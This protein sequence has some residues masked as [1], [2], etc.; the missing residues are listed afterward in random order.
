MIK[1]A[2]PTK[3]NPPKAK[4][5]LLTQLKDPMT[6]E[7]ALNT[8]QNNIADTE[9][10]LVGIGG[11]KVIHCPVLDISSCLFDRS[12]NPCTTGFD[13]GLCKRSTKCVIRLKYTPI[14]F[15]K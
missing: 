8:Y 7:P 1:V 10:E 13:F 6:I 15:P 3:G 2:G 9:G 5:L 11:F 4:L 14:S 12:D